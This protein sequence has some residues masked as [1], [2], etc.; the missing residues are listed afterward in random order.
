M[1]GKIRLTSNFMMLQPGV[2]TI[3]IHKLPNISQSKG[4]QTTKFGLL[5]ECNKIFFFESYAENEA[6]RLVPDLCLFLKKV[7]IR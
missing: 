1:I 3:A 4:N 7:N 5:I 6:R 2:Q